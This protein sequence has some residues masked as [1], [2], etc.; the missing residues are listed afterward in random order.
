MSFLTNAEWKLREERTGKRTDIIKETE[1][2]VAKY[3]E[4]ALLKW[5]YVNGLREK[6]RFRVK[7]T[8]QPKGQE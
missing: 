6:P 4:T 2:I 1:K 7:A 8:S 5:Q 3:G